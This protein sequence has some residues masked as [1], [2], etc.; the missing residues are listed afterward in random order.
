MAD[1]KV[2]INVQLKLDSEAFSR[3]VDGL[4]KS[5][6]P[7][8]IPT[9]IKEKNLG[10]LDTPSKRLKSV[11]QEFKQNSII[12]RVDHSNL[13][14]LN[15]HLSLKVSHLKSV[16]QEFRQNQIAPSVDWR[17]IT[18][19]NQKLNEVVR[20]FSNTKLNIRADTNQS[21]LRFTIDQSDI[22]AQFADIKK[23]LQG[24]RLQISLDTGYI[25]QQIRQSFRERQ[26]IQVDATASSNQSK[27]LEELRNIKSAIQNQKKGFFSNLFVGATESLGAS[28]SKNIQLGI[29][30]VFNI[31][32]SRNARNLAKRGSQVVKEVVVDNE[33]L[34]NAI[35]NAETLLDNRLRKAAYRFG[36]AIVATLENQ[37][38]DITSKI[39]SFTQS[40]TEGVDFSKLGAELSAE[41][42]DIKQQVTKG[43]F[44][45]DVMRRF[46][47]PL[48][49]AI[50]SY[51]EI[52]LKERALPLVRERA[53]ELSRATK[54]KSDMLSTKAV[55]EDTET[56]F[57][58]V[59]GYAGARG[60]SGKTLA[61][62]Q[63][64][65][66]PGVRED[67]KAGSS[68][69]EAIWVKNEDSDIPRESLGDAPKKLVA[70]LTSLGKPNLRGYSKDAV[71]MA[72]QA[73][74]AL[75]KNPNL[76]IK[77]LGE[78]GGGF[79]AEEA[80]QIMKLLG[81]QDASSY[82]AVG[83]PDFIGSPNKDNN[84]LLSPD[85]SLGAE[86]SGRYARL[87]LASRNPQQN[88]LGVQGHPYENYRNAEIAELMN[89]LHG[90]PGS[91]TPE[92]IQGFKA[93]LQQ[94]KSQDKRK[95]DSRQ[96][97]KLYESAF[98]NLQKIRR[99]LLEATGETKNELQSI[100]QQ[101]ESVV[102][103]LAPEDRNLSEAKAA[104]YKAQEYLKY[105]RE[106]PGNEA[107]LVASQVAKELEGVAKGL[108]KDAAKFTGT[109]Q[110]QYTATLENVR[111]T[112]SALLDP[113]IG[114][115]QRQVAQITASQSKYNISNTANNPLVSDFK[116]VI[117]HFTAINRSDLSSAQVASIAEA[118][119][120]NLKLAKQ[121]LESATEETKSDFE[122]IL[123]AFADL[124]VEFT[125]ENADLVKQVISTQSTN[126]EGQKQIA[127]KDRDDK[128]REAEI[129]KI[130]SNPDE[131][132]SRAKNIESGFKQYATIKRNQVLTSQELGDANLVGQEI[133][134]IIKYAA[135]AKKDLDEIRQQLI[136]IGKINKSDSNN[137]ASKAKASI[138]KQIKALEKEL[139]KAGNPIDLT[140]AINKEFES[141]SKQ[142]TLVGRNVSGAIAQGVQQEQAKPTQAVKN[143]AEAMLD[144]VDEVL[145]IQSP[146]K[147]FED[148]GEDVGQGFSLGIRHS[149]SQANGELLKQINQGLSQSDELI[150]QNIKQ[151]TTPKNSPLSFADAQVRHDERQAKLNL[152]FADAQAK[153]NER[154]NKLNLSFA[155]A[156][157][158]HDQRIR[159]LNPITFA[160]AQSRH[161][162]R[163]SKLSLS[164]EE[165]QA[166]HDQRQN[167]LDLSFTNAQTRRDERQKEIAAK[168]PAARTPL[169]LADLEL[170]QIADDVLRRKGRNQIK[171]GLSFESAQS[172]HD[173]RQNKLNLSFADAQARR[174]E[175][176]RSLAPPPAVN[177]PPREV[178][179]SVNNEK[180]GIFAQINRQI[181]ES[182]TLLGQT[183]KEG[184]FIA[185]LNSK[186]PG[187]L[188]NVFALVR[189]FLA[190]QVV[191]L[192][193]QQLQQL[194]VTAFQTSLRFEQLEKSLDFATG[195]QGAENLAF[196]R[197]EVERLSAPLE[198]S[199]KG[200]T[201]LAAAARGTSLE[202]AGVEKIFKAIVQAA[203]VYNL[204]AEQT[205]GALLAVQ[206]MI[207]KGCYDAK[208]EVLTDAGWVYWVETTPEHKFATIDLK[209]KQVT[210]QS[211][212]RLIRY[213]HTGKMLRVASPDV[214][215]LV[216]PDHR[217]VV[218]D[219][220]SAELTI[221]RANEL[222]SKPYFYLVGENAQEVL[223]LPEHLSW[224]DFDDEV[225]CAEVPNT[226]LYIKRNGKECYS[227]NS[228]QAEELRGQLGERIFGIVGTFSRGLGVSTA[229]LN[230]QLELGK[231]GAADLLKGMEQLDKETADGVPSATKTAAASLQ[232]LQNSFAELNKQIGDA[233]NPSVIAVFDTLS[234]SLDFTQKNAHVVKASFATL[235]ITIGIALLPSILLLGGAL[236]TLALTT[237]PL[238]AKAMLAVVKTNPVLVASL[239]V[240]TIGMLFAEDGAKALAN[241][242]TGVSQAQID[243]ADADAKTD[244]KYSEAIKQLLKQVPLTKEQIDE[245]T[246][247]LDD[248]A[249][250]GVNTAKTSEILKNQLFKL[251]TQAEAT[252][253][254]QDALNKSVTESELAFKK[255][256]GLAE[257]YKSRG[258]LSAAQE[259]ARG[260]IAEDAVRDREYESEQRH[261]L[262][263]SSLNSA[264]MIDI[265]NQLAESERLQKSGRKGLEAKKEIELKEE[266]LNVEKEFNQAQVN[267]ANRDAD[268]IKEI[269]ERRIKDFDEAQSILESKQKSGNITEE[270][271]LQDRLAVQQQK[272]EE[273]LA[274]IALRRKAMSK[275]DK[276]GLEALAVEEAKANADIKDAQKVAFDQ[277]IALS[278][279]RADEEIAISQ[280]SKSKGLITEAEFNQQQ[281]DIR[282]EYLDDQLAVLKV[283]SQFIAKTDI[284]GQNQVK[285]EE[286]K[287]L[288]Q[289][290]EARKAFLDGQLSLLEREQNKA[291]D[292]VIQATTER[293]IEI[294]KLINARVLNQEEA[295]S[296]IL[297][298]KREEIA[299]DLELERQKLANLEAFPRF[300]DPTEEE[301]RQTKI[302]AS[303]SQTARLQLQLLQNEKSQQEA[304]YAAYA[305]AVDR[306][307]QAINNRVT[308]A[309]QASNQELRLNTAKEKSLQFQNQLLESE[310]NLRS[311]I[312]N[313]VDAD[314]QILQET[315]KNER[316]KAKLAEAAA[317][318]KLQ[319]ARLQV[320]LDKRS[321]DLQILQTE[322]AQK[323]LE[324]ENQRAQ[325][326]A[327]SEV[328]KADLN[329][330]K[331]E[332]DTNATPE[333]KEEAQLTAS[334]ARSTL[335]D[336]RQ[337]AGFLAQQREL[338]TRNAQTLRQT[339]QLK[340]DADITRAEFEA[341][342]AIANKGERRR[343]LRR[344]RGR[345][346]V[347]VFGVNPN[348][349]G[350]EFSNRLQAYNAANR[351]EALTPLEAYR[352]NQVQNRVTPAL[353][354]IELPK[355]MPMLDKT[356]TSLN[357]AVDSLVE[358]VQKRLST[359]NNVTIATPINNYF[360]ST[361]AKNSASVTTQ[362]I[363]KELYDIGV[364]LGRQ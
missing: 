147:E 257:V 354:Q 40:L 222:E 286:T 46:T 105:L 202:G 7:V 329:V 90:S 256:R 112:Q 240:L 217:M 338:N 345:A 130:T 314:F 75:E 313:Y 234:A 149:M 51:R 351:G 214:D 95:L 65:S 255:G 324:I 266:L 239:A 335:E 279:K 140:T 44:S 94:F 73:L 153:H 261:N 349:D 170:N 118:A 82:L 197:K 278:Q 159:S 115:K 58:A 15:R 319:A 98:K 193:Q 252:A 12:P 248:Q 135:K 100:V 184:G 45:E 285:A 220:Q 260:L 122:Q 301:A 194:G 355:V 127:P 250:R 152:S 22:Y 93:T 3:K 334:D 92:I 200:F 284:D 249:R 346:G 322:Q 230:K 70:L 43:I 121:N 182:L 210:Y 290:T 299:E 50:A 157:E 332:K 168:K 245:L 10:N 54:G 273:Q 181:R 258:D 166:R 231:L 37:E 151:I 178:I 38:G 64:R 247:G 358:L 274:D 218:R 356:V 104:L 56:L 5:F 243:A 192:V 318:A 86:T 141:L 72:A 291:R 190:F 11:I 174:D 6:S 167:R 242:I 359:P 114:I 117:E 213:H 123:K 21:D 333:Q 26:A 113:A 142:Q 219:P 204:T 128:Q 336:V 156:L 283:K 19:L 206:Q 66:S 28:L 107:A 308:A 77:F 203:R 344:L 340:S 280:S 233:I 251:Q 136:A 236:K 295:S 263:M 80:D 288:Q 96:V 272:A 89:F 131:L 205:E 183:P 237:L 271:L 198:T 155:N 306:V 31:D 32:I 133:Q 154:Q 14:A 311:A 364:L 199:I 158:R 53:L 253:A 310:K 320:E 281:Y 235:A 71:E 165:A 119:F 292:I 325:R 25:S 16:A 180:I 303:K 304:V 275:T 85:E 238:V 59:G 69:S 120:E 17:E 226:T 347:R 327:I 97:E 262:N 48:N 29:K 215:L 302:R 277:R 74:A 83:T 24:Q 315:T 350:G 224:V 137:E 357:T 34:N 124:V 343:A 164:F 102:I 134:D 13:E 138:T 196:V 179:P 201:G 132:S 246:K 209:T 363:R 186:I 76:K 282:S 342:N 41:F 169:N 148:R 296:A 4:S 144:T 171:T 189:G 339:Q 361:D 309:N 125:P 176:I 293:E 109:S 57:I 221:I 305:K 1:K 267:L 326:K 228:I 63:M 108:E 191:S 99:F 289:R 264:R 126:L 297:Q 49:E 160:D 212:T 323:R 35:K 270:K 195:G 143:M 36:D 328:A 47:A 362:N 68:K 162:E 287:I 341:A 111:K 276:E 163:Q 42:Q 353:P 259:R 337:D 241:A 175:R 101:F 177:I 227:G 331:L 187:L 79:A 352:A 145:K 229:E 211:P 348:A 110:K 87:G 207:S 225:F 39:N 173:E 294:Q 23:E 321:L 33:Q 330:A 298:N 188:K 317:N 244:F 30:D 116:T 88:I 269:R 55:R 106:Q 62:G 129:L 307:T 316:E 139:R 61:S 20:N 84:K 67:V 172:R 360:T 18:D 60:L 52:A 8:E 150:S 265:K 268:R 300:D 208:T 216:T 91:A 185:D 232:R 254:A 9:E 27:Q 81:L 2:S 161:N 312:N 146:S 103:D 78:S 223:V